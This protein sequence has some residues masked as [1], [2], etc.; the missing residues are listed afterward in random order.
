[1]NPINNEINEMIKNYLIN[2]GFTNT[3]NEFEKELEGVGGREENAQVV[4]KYFEENKFEL[5]FESWN[6][7]IPQSLRT[8]DINTIELEFIIRLYFSVVEKLNKKNKGGLP[9][10]SFQDYLIF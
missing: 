2:N 5:F 1:M 7:F 4:L 10:K 6:A 9:T 3:I 8:R